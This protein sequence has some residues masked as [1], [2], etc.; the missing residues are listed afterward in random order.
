[1]TVALGL[2]LARF[3]LRM[4]LSK[5]FSKYLAE[6][7]VDVNLA[8]AAGSGLFVGAAGISA[9]QARCRGRA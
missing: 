8:F 6:W 5:A 9:P 3:R 2:V 7:E 4:A 1:M